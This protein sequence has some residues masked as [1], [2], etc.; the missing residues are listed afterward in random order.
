MEDTAKLGKSQ[1][2][3]LAKLT[4]GHEEDIDFQNDRIRNKLD[5]T[6]FEADEATRAQDHSELENILT[7]QKLQV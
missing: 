2:I 3:E 1:A 5:E 4:P 7:K 6:H